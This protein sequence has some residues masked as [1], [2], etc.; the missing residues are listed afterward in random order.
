MAGVNKVILIGNLGGDP[1]VR[2]L[3]N[4][5]KVANFSMATTESYKNKAG[6]KVE[7]TEW[8]RVVI[9][10]KL[11]EIVEKYLKKGAK[12]YVEGKISYRSYED[13]DGIKKYTTDILAQNMTMLG[14]NPQGS[15]QESTTAP[16][17]MDQQPSGETDDL[18]F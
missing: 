13:K 12:V 2:A 14:G 8:H 1:E 4:G 3:E 16:A 11:A 10:G 6:E 9:W 17:P 5:N 7:S 15:G 18:P